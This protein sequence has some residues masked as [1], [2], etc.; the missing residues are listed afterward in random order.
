MMILGHHSEP[1][2]LRFLSGDGLRCLGS[3]NDGLVVVAGSGHAHFRG[4][5]FQ[6]HA[7]ASGSSG[8]GAVV[9]GVHAG[10][11]VGAGAEVAVVPAFLVAVDVMAA[12]QG[13][14]LGGW[15]WRY[16]VHG[17]APDEDR[18]LPAV[19]VTSE[20]RAGLTAGDVVVEGD[21]L[22]GVPVVGPR[23]VTGGGEG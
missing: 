15:R 22:D 7:V 6:F 20:G 17:H 19:H 10:I 4:K 12:G 1:Q 2:R 8:A 14:E 9:G 3:S 18:G 23:G 5:G 11:E 21:L 13:V 16:A